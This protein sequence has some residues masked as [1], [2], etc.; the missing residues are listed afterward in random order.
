[1]TRKQIAEMIKELHK[2]ALKEVVGK[3]GPFRPEHIKPSH[4]GVNTQGQEKSSPNDFLHRKK[5]VIEAARIAVGNRL[6]KGTLGN[7]KKRSAVH[8]K[9]GSQSSR[10]RYLNKNNTLGEEDVDL[11]PTATGQN[12][13]EKEKITVNPKITSATGDTTKNTT[14]KETKEK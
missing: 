5:S 1:M 8:I 3:P 7:L 6:G 10:Y 11:G 9:Q 4:K 2:K 12:G 14:V 13:K